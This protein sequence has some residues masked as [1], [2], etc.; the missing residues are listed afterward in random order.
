MINSLV[1]T[2]LKN[3]VCDGYVDCPYGNDEGSRCTLNIL[4]VQRVGNAVACLF[5]LISCALLVWIYKNQ[6]DSVVKFASPRFLYIIV[7]GAIIG[8]LSIVNWTVKPSSIIC[9]VPWW[10]M[11]IAFIFIFG[12]LF[13]KTYRLVKLFGALT[14][15][16]QKITD[17]KLLPVVLILLFFEIIILT[18]WTFI[19]PPTYVPRSQLQPPSSYTQ[20]T[21]K[22]NLIFIGL[23]V[24]FKA[25]IMVW[26]CYMSI[27]IR[28]IDSRFNEVK[29]IGFTVYFWGFVAIVGVPSAF[30]LNG[31]SP[32]QFQVFSIFFVVAV[33]TVTLG[34]LF[35]NKLILVHKDPNVTTK[36]LSPMTTA[37]DGK[38]KGVLAISKDPVSYHSSNNSSQEDV[39]TIGSTLRSSS[40]KLSMTGSFKNMGGSG[41]KSAISNK[42]KIEIPMDNAYLLL[43]SEE[44]EDS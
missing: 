3:Y 16:Q 21:S 15:K 6:K 33:I 41:S 14:I 29:Y 20:C 23:Y 18:L 22:Y 35:I 38:L 12:A 37:N 17:W 36:L 24:G 31:S 34:L 43:K 9:L 40:K 2:I 19:D 26:G 32:G 8:Y 4:I 1:N 11:G 42:R 28:N 39:K 27:L 13:A 7:M 10:L 30:V 5:F 25:I 44:P